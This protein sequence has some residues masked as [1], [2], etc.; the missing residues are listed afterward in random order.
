V[1]SFHIYVQGKEAEMKK[2]ILFAFVVF[3]L[4]TACMAVSFGASPATPSAMDT[5]VPPVNPVVADKVLPTESPQPIDIPTLMASPTSLPPTVAATAITAPQTWAGIYKQTGVGSIPISIIIEKVKGN[6][7]TGKMVWS[8]KG[9]FRGATTTISGEFVTSFGDEKDLS[10]WKEHP[11]YTGEFSGSWIKWTETGFVQ[12]RGYTLGGWYYGH[13]REDGS[14][15]GIY[16]LNDEATSY[17][18]SD[19][20]K[21]EI[22]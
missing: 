6:T 17:A 5:P 14:M 8:G 1:S 20:W 12:G 18:S 19:F 10:K 2:Q 21:L 15:A 16:F 11:D 22:K 7:F 13:I 9:N 4:M 3:L